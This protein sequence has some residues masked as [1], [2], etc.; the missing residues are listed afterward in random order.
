MTILPTPPDDTPGTVPTTQMSPYGVESMITGPSRPVAAGHTHEAYPRVWAQ[1]SDPRWLDDAQTQFNTELKPGDVWLAIDFVTW[2]GWDG[3]NYDI[4][5]KPEFFNGATWTVFGSGNGTV[6]VSATEPPGTDHGVGDIWVKPGSPSVLAGVWDGSAWAS[7]PAGPQGPPGATGPQGPQGEGAQVGEGPN[8]NP[9]PIRTFWYD[10]DEDAPPGT[11]GPQGPKG[12]KGDPGQIGPAG[13]AGAQGVAGPQ[14]PAGPAGADST[15]AGPQGP[16]GPQGVPG[17]KGDPGEIGPEGPQ[18]AEGPKGEQGTGINIKGTV[19]TPGDLPSSGNNPGDGYIIESTGDLWMWDGTQ[20]ANAGQIV[21]PQ[22][23][24][25]P[26]GPQGPKGDK[27]DQGVR[28]PGAQVGEGPDP[29]PAP[30]TTFWYDTDA[31]A[32]GGIEGPQGPPGPQ[33]PQG[34]AGPA[35]AQGV[36]GPQGPKGDA[37]AASTVAGPQGPQ[38]PQGV[39]GEKG[40]PGEIGPA[41]PQG[42]DGVDGAQGPQGPQGPIG[43]TGAQG[44]QGPGAQVGEGPDPTPAPNATF[45]YDTDADAPGGIE[46]PQGPPGPAGPQGPAGPAGPIGNTGPQ[47]PKGDPGADSTVAGPQGPQGPQG[48]PGLKGDPGEMGPQGPQGVEGPEGPIGATGATGAAGA[49][50]PQGPKGDKGDTGA[51]GPQ[52]LKG[53]TGAQGPQGVKGDTGAT[54]PQ[55]PIGNTGPQGPQGV[56]GVGAQIGEGPSPTPAPNGTFWYDTDDEAP[57]QAVGPQGPK[58]DKG[59]TGPQGATGPAG[60]QGV[61]GPQGLKGDKGDT[62]P[63]GPAG[64]QGPQGLQG[65]QGTVGPVGPEGPQGETGPAGPGSGDVLGPGASTDNGLVTWNGTTGTLVKDGSGLKA[66]G[67]NITPTGA[68]LLLNYGG[69]GF[70]AVRAGQLGVVRE[71]VGDW[72]TLFATYRSIANAD[73]DSPNFVVYGL[74]AVQATYEIKVKNGG[75]A[76]LKVDGGS[77]SERQV[78]FQSYGSLRWTF[79]V[80]PNAETGGNAGSDFTVARYS[81]TGQWLDNPIDINRSNGGVSVNSLWIKSGGWIRNLPTP[82]QNDEAATKGYVDTQDATKVAKSGDTMTGSLYVRKPTGASELVVR[83][84]D[85]ETYL[86][87]QDDRANGQNFDIWS[88]GGLARFLVQANNANYNFYGCDD[89]GG[90]SGGGRL[91]FQVSRSTLKMTLGVATASTDT[92]RTVADKGYVDQSMP[93]GAII[94]YGGTTAPTGWHLC[95]GSVHGSSALQ[96][97]I[98]SANT[99]DLRDRFIVGVS[100]SKARGATGGAE[101]HTLTTA[102]MPSHSHGGATGTDSPDHGHWVPASGDHNH[103]LVVQTNTTTT[104]SGRRVTGGSGTIGD[105]TANGGYHDHG[106]SHGANA[107]HAHGI[108]AEGGNGAH[109][110]MPPYYALVYIIKKA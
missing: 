54:G 74:G 47:G 31:E 15:V 78:Q 72:N 26:I 46:G 77:G 45:W 95:D 62:G 40:D 52:G 96:T 23:P 41:G 20:W 82:T 39:P 110:N 21:G 35:G 59:D 104:G 93:I 53:D 34:P 84:A 87:R 70:D 65:A 100:G 4:T 30:V 66:S 51:T 99:P 29:T 64:P 10:T 103:G 43:N 101:T 76:Y 60:P 85:A 94:A 61:A 48:V 13:P 7:I 97:L 22:G 109:N 75:N 71:G 38:G 11:V 9:A 50:G 49:T 19:A 102:E 107:R 89:T 24:A 106:H 14:G 105:G 91:V 6:I 27:G 80:A 2:N 69:G 67:G 81:D 25:G 57:P 92:A 18:G 16:P 88:V 1:L 42:A 44:P 36:A 56:Q 108:N 98:G 68:R 63:A 73:G 90:W 32:P 17:P 55:G 58:G 33:G 86:T 37:G 5:A 28:G 3:T 79:G 8:P 12:D 83:S